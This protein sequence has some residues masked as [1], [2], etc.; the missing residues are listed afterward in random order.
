[1]QSYMNVAIATAAILHGDFVSGLNTMAN[2]SSQLLINMYNST[3]KSYFATGYA[4]QNGLSDYGASGPGTYVAT[5]DECG[6]SSGAGYSWIFTNG[7]NAIS[8]DRT[9]PAY[10]LPWTVAVGD[11]YRAANYDMLYHGTA[12]PPSPFTDESDYVITSIAT[13]DFETATIAGASVGNAGGFL[14]PTGQSNPSTGTLVGS[15]NDGDDYLAWQIAGLSLMSVHGV[16]GASAALANA[17]NRWTGGV[18]A[19]NTSCMWAFQGT[20]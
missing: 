15:T 20:V 5:L 6:I 14:I 1:M 10:G 11:T 16:S 7:S 12:T 8:L 19:Y 4:F 18:S 3:F 9:Q 17:N 2:F 13:P